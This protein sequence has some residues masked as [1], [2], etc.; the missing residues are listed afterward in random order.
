[1]STSRTLGPQKTAEASAEVMWKKD[2]AVRHLGFE[3]VHMG[4]GEAT[5]QG[6]VTETM[7][8]AHGT[9][10]GGYIF[11]LAD[12]AFAYACNSHNAVAVAQHCSITYVHAVSAGDRLTATAREVSRRGRS[13]VYDVRITNQHDTPVAEFRGLSRVIAGHHLPEPSKDNS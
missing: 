10:H 5:I 9:C 8:N 6:T 12:S 2:N 1:M 3:L 13:G 7:T 4:P 11:L